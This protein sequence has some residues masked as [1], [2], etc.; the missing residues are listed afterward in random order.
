MFVDHHCLYQSVVRRETLGKPKIDRKRGYFQSPSC[1]EES[2]SK[3]KPE[4]SSKAG[5]FKTKVEPFYERG[6]GSRP[7]WDLR[8]VDLKRQTGV[9]N[10]E[11]CSQCNGTGETLCALCE[12]VDYYAKDGSGKVTCPACN[13]K[14]YVPCHFCYATGKAI[15]LKEGWWE[16]DLEKQVRK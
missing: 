8:P 11:L 12:G 14:K 2:I 9:E 6:S 5:Y 4:S 3:K 16:Q 1:S 15:Q 13:D 7:I 10:S